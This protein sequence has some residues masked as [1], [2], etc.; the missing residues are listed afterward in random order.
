M[1]A[2][3][4]GWHAGRSL[5]QRISNDQNRVMRATANDNQQLRVCLLLHAVAEH[6]LE[7]CLLLVVPDRPAQYVTSSGFLPA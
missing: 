7:H 3:D 4:R 5:L 2:E 1:R 6:Q